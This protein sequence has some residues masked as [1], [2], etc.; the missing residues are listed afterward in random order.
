MNIGNNAVLRERL[1]AEYT[2]GTLRGPARRRFETWLRE[3]AELR[4]LVATWQGR[5]AGLAEMGKPVTPP[6]RVWTGIER[7]L[8]PSSPSSPAAPWWQFWRL[9]AAR[10]WAGMA[11]GAGAIAVV[12]GVLLAGRQRQAIGMA[13]LHDLSHSEVAAQLSQPLGTVK[14][15]I[16]RGLDRLRECLSNREPA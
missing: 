9:G 3:D 12:L 13:Y 4:V 10:P 11:L 7:R 1:A 15:W 8:Q 16:R 14:T 2:L 6:A 5:L